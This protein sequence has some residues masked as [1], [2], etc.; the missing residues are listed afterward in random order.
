MARFPALPRPLSN[1]VLSRELARG[2]KQLG[3]SEHGNR[4]QLG[5]D[6]GQ[7]GQ[8]AALFLDVIE[9]LKTYSRY[10]NSSQTAHELASE[11]ERRTRMLFRKVLSVRRKLENLTKYAEALHPVF[12]LEYSRAAKR[13]LKALE[14]LKADSSAGDFYRSLKSEY[15]L[16]EHPR[17]LG[18]VELYWF[19]HHECRCS[20][21]DSEVR[22]ALVVNL[23]SPRQ[24]PLKYIIKYRDAESQGSSAVRIAV[25]RYRWRTG[26]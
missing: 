7:R 1:S 17:H 3:D 19:F 22:A 26:D 8:L 14:N 16:L 2:E 12:G 6:A 15:P 18:I 24:S 5:L 13:C 9:A 11:G 10:R 25:S 20:R 4:I 21:H 23:A